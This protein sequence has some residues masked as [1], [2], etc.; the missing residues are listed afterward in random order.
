MRACSVQ[1]NACLDNPVF[2]KKAVRKSKFAVGRC[3]FAP[4]SSYR[5]ISLGQQVKSG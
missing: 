3:S 2:A 1:V 5:L 4:V